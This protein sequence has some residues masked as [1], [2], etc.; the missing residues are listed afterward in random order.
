MK[1]VG[2]TDYTILAAVQ[3]SELEL[4]RF[5][6]P[7]LDFDVPA[8]PG[9]H[10]TLDAGTGGG[11]YRRRPRSGRLHHQPEIRSGNRQP[12]VGRTVLTCQVLTR[13][14]MVSTSSKPTT[15]SLRCCVTAA[16]CCTWKKCSTAIRAAGATNR[17]SSSATPQW[18]VSMDQKGLARSPR[19]RSKACS[20]SRT[21]ARRVSNRWSLTALTGVSPVSVPGAC[22]CRCSCTKKPTNCTR[23]PRTDGRSGETR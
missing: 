6:H 13:L 18:F 19:K 17:R 4:M 7:F 3:G 23:V 8:I 2:A 21:G 15:S 9:D 11:A 16:R 22:R 20:G 14:W 12:G 1:R 10:V 5:K